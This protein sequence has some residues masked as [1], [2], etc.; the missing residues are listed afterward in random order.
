MVV[1]VDVVVFFMSNFIT[2]ITHKTQ[3]MNEQRKQEMQ[4]QATMF[5]QR[6]QSPTK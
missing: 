4:E 6:F 3:L 5:M 1:I 2:N